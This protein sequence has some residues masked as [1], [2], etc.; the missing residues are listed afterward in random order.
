MSAPR[1]GGVRTAV[2]LAFAAGIA[3]AGARASAGDAP[4]K[5]TPPRPAFLT[6]TFD[7]RA[8]PAAATRCEGCHTEGGWGDAKFDHGRTGF[9][10]VGAHEKVPCQACHARDYV[11]RVADS[12]AGCHRDRHAGT[13]GLH[14]EGCHEPRSWR[15]TLFGADGHRTTAF[16]LTG[17]HAAIPCQE[18]HGDARDGSF[19]RAPLAC[20]DCHRADLA[21]AAFRSIDHTAAHFDTNCQTC[22]TTLAFFPARF[23]AHDACFTVSTG[24]H[25]TLRCQ[26]CHA[27]PSSLALDGLC[28]NPDVRCVS[29]HTHNCDVSARQHQGVMGFEC[30][31][32]KC[33]EC[34]RPTPSR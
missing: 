10:L 8:R 32:R 24:S 27:N 2:A 19:S 15:E 17:K 1:T 33:F 6:P 29:C 18:C 5:A 3:S 30:T 4:V 31:D 28:A 16:P 14:C 20:V 22:H 12:C 25:R 21:T 34:H 13:L 7:R 26:D 23:A 9:A 11:T